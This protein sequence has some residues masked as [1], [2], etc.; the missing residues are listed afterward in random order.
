MSDQNRPSVIERAL[1]LAASGNYPSAGKVRSAL[2]QEGY[3]S[4]DSHVSFSLAKRVTI[5]CREN[6]RRPG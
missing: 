5:L 3:A 4:V 6:F 2:K 1:Q